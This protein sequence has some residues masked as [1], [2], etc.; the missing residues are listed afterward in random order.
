MSQ[1]AKTTASAETPTPTRT[2]IEWLR[3]IAVEDHLEWANP[4]VACLRTPL[5]VLICGAV[6]ALL[7]GLCVAPQGYAIFGAILSVIALGLAWP[8]IAMKGVRGELDFATRRGREGKP[9]VA[10]FVVVNRWPW[11][12]WGLAV[13]DPLLAGQ[14]DGEAVL[15]LARIEG[16]SR[17]T[18]KCTL[19]PEQR[20]LYPRQ[21]VSLGSGFPF[22]L[23]TA[24][25]PVDV[26]KKLIVWP[27]TFW[28]PPLADGASR[29]DW[30][31]ETSDACVGMQGTRL[32]PREHR[33]GDSLR[34]VHWAKSARYDQLIV[35]EREDASVEDHTVVVD[36]DPRRHA[37]D[38]PDSTLEWSLRIAASICEAVVGQRGSVSLWLGDEPLTA[39][40]PGDDLRRLLDA[41]AMLEP[42][43]R[44]NAG[45][46]RR[47]A[48][49]WSTIAIGTEQ[50]PR[51]GERFLCVRPRSSPSRTEASSEGSAGAW[52]AVDA[53][54]DVAGQVLRG[55]RSGVR[56]PSRAG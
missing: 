18:F 33:P 48:R 35:S 32:G 15:A 43:G 27:E 56:R 4:Y 36:I 55:W 40:T 7:C 2:W 44:A 26:A 23:Y 16:W 9:F 10:D 52:I 37:G 45:K 19:T 42:G 50:T 49:T 53:P 28:L 41:I 13:S 38:G 1:P 47:R 51:T 3:W 17:A 12:V 34:D 20:G 11:P 5:G 31:G 54:G 30:R 29:P 25:R 22:G 6:A 24:S 39:N 8:W 21:E 14:R 46:S